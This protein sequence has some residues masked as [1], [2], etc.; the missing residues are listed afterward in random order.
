MKK[1]VLNLFLAAAF[2]LMSGNVVAAVDPNLSFS[3]ATGAYNLNDTF[4]VTMLIDSAGQVAGA[5]DMIGTFDSTKLEITKIETATSMAFNKTTTGGSCSFNK[6]DEWPV[7][8]F[9]ASCNSSMTAGDEVVNGNLMVITFKAKAAGTA[10]VSYT[11][12][13]QPSDSNIVQTTP[14]KDIIVCSANGSGSYTIN[15]TIGTTTSSTPTTTPA[16]TTTELPQTG[17]I[18]STVG[19]IVFGAVSILSALFL[20]FY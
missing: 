7:G 11:C 9:S 13:G 4:T 8:K 15:S 12:N 3:P 17:G 20:K 5:V 18:A 6:Q 14:I 1:T 19:L 16:A 10:I 2:L